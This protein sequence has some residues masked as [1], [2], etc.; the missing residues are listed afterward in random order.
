MFAALA[1]TDSLEQIVSGMEQGI[2]TRELIAEVFHLAE[3]I[4]RS[5][6]G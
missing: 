5:S 4:E 2:G 6:R 1:I 3:D